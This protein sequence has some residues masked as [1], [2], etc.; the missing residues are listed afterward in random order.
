VRDFSN[1]S[2]SDDVKFRIY[3]LAIM[4]LLYGYTANAAGIVIERDASGA[5]AFG[6]SAHQAIQ[7]AIA[8]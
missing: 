2:G 3:I 1:T 7:A 8:L 5:S 4:V 6:A